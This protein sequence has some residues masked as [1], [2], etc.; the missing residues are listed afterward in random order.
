MSA[1]GRAERVWQPGTD[2]G[3][4]PLPHG[5]TL[6][7]CRCLESE[8]HAGTVFCS[9]TLSAP[10]SAAPS[11]APS[12]PAQVPVR[13]FDVLSTPSPSM[14]KSFVHPSRASSSRA[15]VQ[16]RAV[17]TSALKKQLAA[18]ELAIKE[19]CTV[20]SRSSAPLQGALSPF[21]ALNISL[22]R[23]CRRCRGGRRQLRHACP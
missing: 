19:C 16:P 20:L 21:R 4:N 14:Y 8:K 3:L 15:P 10:F 7:G 1:L 6:L 22:R 2:P 5:S 9:S 12:H 23:R 11:F 13:A 17:V 18:V